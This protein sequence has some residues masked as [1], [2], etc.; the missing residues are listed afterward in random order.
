M[1]DLA[2]EAIRIPLGFPLNASV[3][4]LFVSPPIP[5]KPMLHHNYVAVLQSLSCFN[6]LNRHVDWVF[7]G[8]HE[9]AEHYFESQNAMLHLAGIHGFADPDSLFGPMF[10]NNFPVMGGN[11]CSIFVCRALGVVSPTEAINFV[12]RLEEGSTL[13]GDVCN[14]NTR[15]MTLGAGGVSVLPFIDDES[16]RMCQIKYHNG[17]LRN[18]F[19]Y[20]QL[21]ALPWSVRDGSAV[22]WTLV[23]NGPRLLVTFEKVRFVPPRYELVIPVEK[24]LEAVQFTDVLK[25]APF[26]SVSQDTAEFVLGHNWKY[27]LWGDFYYFT[28]FPFRQSKFVLPKSLVS[29][30]ELQVVGMSRTVKTFELLV[31]V[32]QRM[33]ISSGMRYPNPSTIIVGS[34]I[35]AMYSGLSVE[36]ELVR[37][38]SDPVAARRHELSIKALDCGDPFSPSI[39]TVAT[40]TALILGGLGLSYYVSKHA[41][42]GALSNRRTVSSGLLPLRSGF[43]AIGY[44]LYR[45]PFKLGFMGI[46]IGYPLYKYLSR[47]RDVE[48]TVVHS[49]CPKEF[50]SK[51]IALD[52][53]TKIT[54]DGVDFTHSEF[55]L[56]QCKR[57][58]AARLA[59][60]GVK[61]RPPVY[62]CQ[63]LNA[64]ALAFKT[65][66]GMELNQPT[67]DMVVEYMS[68]LKTVY[69]WSNVLNENIVS[70]TR[71]AGEYVIQFTK[72]IVPMPVLEWLL[73]FPGPKR[74]MYSNTNNKLE[75]GR[76][77]VSVKREGFVKFE[78]YMKS[79]GEVVEEFDPRLIINFDPTYNVVVGP[80]M[81]AAGNFMKL[82]LL[83]CVNTENLVEVGFVTQAVPRR[84]SYASGLNAGSLGYWFDHWLSVLSP[85][86]VTVP[87]P[88]LQANSARYLP[89]VGYTLIGIESD[90]SRFDGHKHASFKVVNDKFMVGMFK[91]PDQ[92]RLAI[93]LAATMDA[94]FEVRT[95][96]TKQRLCCQTKG[97]QSSGHVNTS[98]DNSQMSTAIIEHCFRLLNAID[99][100]LVIYAAVI[101]L[102]DD[103]AILCYMPNVLIPFVTD[104]FTRGYSDF[105]HEGEVKVHS[106]HNIRQL[107]FCSGYFYPTLKNG[108]PASLWAPKI[109]RILS[110]LSWCK[111]P[112]VRPED[113]VYSVLMGY[114][115]VFPAIPVLEAFYKSLVTILK[116]KGA[117]VIK[118]PV[119]YDHKFSL[120]ND[121]DQFRFDHHSYLYFDR[122][123]GY[124]ECTAIRASYYISQLTSF[125]MLDHPSIMDIVNID[126]PL[127][128][129]LRTGR[130]LT[131][132]VVGNPSTGLWDDIRRNA[133]S[134]WSTTIQFSKDVWGFFEHPEYVAFIKGLVNSGV[135]TVMSASVFNVFTEVVHPLA[136]AYG[137]PTTPQSVFILKLAYD[138]F[139]DLA[140]GKFSLIPILISLYRSAWFY[141]FSGLTA[142]L[143]NLPFAYFV[144][145]NYAAMG[146]PIVEEI[147]REYVDN[148]Y[149]PT[150]SFFLFAAETMQVY[151]S[152]PTPLG[153]CLGLMGKFFTHMWFLRR[154]DLK[155][156][157]QRHMLFNVITNLTEMTWNPSFAGS[158]LLSIDIRNKIPC[159]VAQFCGFENL[160]SWVCDKGEVLFDFGPFVNLY[161]PFNGVIRPQ[162][163]GDVVWSVEFIMQM[164]T[165]T[166]VVTAVLVMPGFALKLHTFVK[167]LFLLSRWWCGS[168]FT[169]PSTYHSGGEGNYE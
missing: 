73:G 80:Y 10:V 11:P 48:Y 148:R 168:T 19:D 13:Y 5:T 66:L 53:S 152:F 94:K 119:E 154:G 81:K 124:P 111:D 20:T 122:N 31:G 45:F 55:P 18:E 50:E 12:H 52:R 57:K 7:N 82:E 115:Y 161:S 88:S 22:V 87:I 56:D 8:P 117:N 164:M 60:F 133:L 49:V 23:A 138:Y 100:R 6:Q 65:R 153:F 104:T 62:S 59:G 130:F 128:G 145:H 54:L 105:C 108:V 77:L 135:P 165:S 113:F 136:T 47:K 83:P 162:V 4:E 141:K 42:M 63:C 112:H 58:I 121:D 158:A 155:T 70:I 99:P 76:V 101:A 79:D 17:S 75:L 160:K 127:K 24:V 106:F 92:R 93:L 95:R 116:K 71:S 129:R 30:L 27:H 64:L 159:N 91:R 163:F 40:T 43:N 74:L 97:R 89:R 134:A 16:N 156:R 9:V 166:P 34:V 107:S 78:P 37:S 109:G 33:Y 131:D 26:D 36:E 149:F 126:C 102:G 72:Q 41:L 143:I 132:R 68:C 140:S 114:R 98:V 144:G 32:A 96:N 44:I 61:S 39:P 125:E 169:F 14:P 38:Y 15:S 150:F 139:M 90:G 151:R 142:A 35:F 85:P 2:P 86:G 21:N 69:D 167:P 137:E 46:L 118:L 147:L 3:L 29:Y 146:A 28:N 84:Y 25:R 157:I 1:V 110:R 120:Q 51:P 123:F 103:T 67:D